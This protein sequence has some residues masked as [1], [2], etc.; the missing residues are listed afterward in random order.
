VSIKENEIVDDFLKDRYEDYQEWIDNGTV[1]HTSKVIPIKESLEHK[2]WVLPTEQV[3]EIIRNAD[4]IALTKCDCRSH[5]GR[6]SNPVEVCLLLN[7]YGRAFI[8]KGVSREISFEEATS[9]LKLANESG[10]VHL[11]LYRPDHQLYALCSCCTCCCHDLQLLM[12]FGKDMLVAHSDYVV[13]TD[14]DLCTHC[15]ECVERCPFKA[16]VYEDD[17]VVFNAQKCY[18]CGLCVTTCPMDAIVMKHREEFG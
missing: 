4:T 18:G 8:N 2:Q 9:V 13:E 5:Y 12:E 3:L 10:L 7:E 11:S 17:E 15:G 16:R 14:M 6:C 1:Q